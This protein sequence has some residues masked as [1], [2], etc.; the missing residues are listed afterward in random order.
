MSWVGFGIQLTRKIERNNSIQNHH[1]LIITE[2]SEKSNPKMSIVHLLALKFQVGFG[3]VGVATPRPKLSQDQISARL[4]NPYSSPIL[5][6]KSTQ[7]KLGLTMEWLAQQFS[8]AA[9]Y[10]GWHL[11]TQFPLTAPHLKK[12]NKITCCTKFPLTALH[13]RKKK[14]TECV[15]L[16]L[17]TLHLKNSNYPLPILLCSSSNFIKNSNSNLTFFLPWRWV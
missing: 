14:N 15:P 17:T 2:I 9:F 4:Q 1:L 3:S 8:A 6:R 11:F 10:L 16:S 7:P 13:L 5:I 12:K